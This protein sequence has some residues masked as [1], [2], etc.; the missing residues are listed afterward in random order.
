[1]KLYVGNLSVNISNEELSE[2]FRAVGSVEFASVIEDRATGRSRG[3]GFVEMP[4]TAES[5][6][7]VAQLNGME[8]DGHQLKV[9]KAKPRTDRKTATVA[10]YSSQNA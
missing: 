3:F 10:D 8:V 9:D 4:S 2:L 6:N 7:A 1:M 5:E